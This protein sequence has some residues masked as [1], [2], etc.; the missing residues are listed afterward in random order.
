MDLETHFAITDKLEAGRLAGWLSEYLVSWHGPSGQL[1][2]AVT[3]W[4][5][6]DRSE[7]TVRTYLIGLLADLVAKDKIDIAGV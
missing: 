2:P 3:V 5:E 4:R 6:P 1:L 7:P